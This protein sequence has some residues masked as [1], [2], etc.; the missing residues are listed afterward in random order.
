MPVSGSVNTDE[1]VWRD[2][3]RLQQS[4]AKAERFSFRFN[5]WPLNL[6]SCSHADS[7]RLSLTD[8]SADASSLICCHLTLKTNKGWLWWWCQCNTLSKLFIHLKGKICWLQGFFTTWRPSLKIFLFYKLCK[9]IYKYFKKDSK[10]NS[11]FDFTTVNFVL[12]KTCVLNAEKAE[13]STL[14]ILLT[15]LKHVY[16]V[17]IVTVMFHTCSPDVWRRCFIRVT[18]CDEIRSPDGMLLCGNH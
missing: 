2:A 3:T 17:L 5:Y 10:L 16:V 13:V 1:L 4:K 18:A 14:C 7:T 12:I 6:Q 8:S 9:K 15:C 11:R